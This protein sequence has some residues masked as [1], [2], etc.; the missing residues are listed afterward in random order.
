MKDIRK[1]RYFFL[2]ATF[3][4]LGCVQ[5]LDFVNGEYKLYATV[6]IQDDW[7]FMPDGTKANGVTRYNTKVRSFSSICV[8]KK[9]DDMERTLMHELGHA[10]LNSVGED[11][12]A[13]YD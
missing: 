2:L 8:S 4:F 9:S 10:G 5:P 13:L 1:M 7:C 6:I 11:A 12:M 3:L